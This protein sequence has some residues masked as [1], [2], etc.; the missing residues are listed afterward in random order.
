MTRGGP[1]TP[2]SALRPPTAPRSGQVSEVSAVIDV[3]GLSKTFGAVRAVS[4]ISFTVTAGEVF[5]FLG[6]NGAGKSTTIRLLLGLYHATAG[7]MSVL[8][9]DPSTDAADVSETALHG[10][11]ELGG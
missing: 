1:S 8:G 11:V 4:D 7:R 3:Q 2:A 10:Y 9:R 6:P 5:G